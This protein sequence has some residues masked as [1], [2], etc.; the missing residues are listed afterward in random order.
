MR[1]P[2]PAPAA[3]VGDIARSGDHRRD[4]GHGSPDR[5]FQMGQ[6]KIGVVHVVDNGP[7]RI[8]L[9]PVQRVA[10]ALHD[11]DVRR[12]G[13]QDPPA[14]RQGQPRRQHQRAPAKRAERR[15][16]VVDPEKRRPRR[17]GR[18][19]ENRQRPLPRP[20]R[21]RSRRTGASRNAWRAGLSAARSVPGTCGARAT[22]TA[23]PPACQIA[24]SE[25]LMSGETPGLRTFRQQQNRRKS[26]IYTD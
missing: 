2:C 16:H 9:R 13:V 21:T 23:M 11:Q 19:Q 15:R 6:M 26:P 14:L 12:G 3:P 20:C 17:A 8:E 24:V 22:G 10:R 4:P 25:R 18:G 5:G 1:L 7:V